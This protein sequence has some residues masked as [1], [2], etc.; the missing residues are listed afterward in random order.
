MKNVKC[1][2]NQTVLL[3]LVKPS[4]KPNPSLIFNPSD[5]DLLF[6]N[7]REIFR[8]RGIYRKIVELPTTCIVKSRQCQKMSPSCQIRKRN[9]QFGQI[10]KLCCLL[11]LKREIKHASGFLQHELLIVRARK[12]LMNKKCKDDLNI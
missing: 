3:K 12:I 1:V 7:S 4:V 10:S 6:A 2:I 5:W 8:Y 9:Q 11:V